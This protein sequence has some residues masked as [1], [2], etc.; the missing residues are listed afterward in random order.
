MASRK[1]SLSICS[2]AL[3]ACSSEIRAC[4]AHIA[5]SPMSTGSEKIAAITPATGKG[6]AVKRLTTPLERLLTTIE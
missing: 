3:V 2:R 4:A 5:P 1:L 6:D